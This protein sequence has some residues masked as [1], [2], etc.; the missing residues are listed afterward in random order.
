MDTRLLSSVLG[1]WV[2][3]ASLCR[4]QLAVANNIFQFTNQYFPKRAKWWPSVIR[5]IKMMM[6]LTPALQHRVYRPTWPVVFASDAEGANNTDHGGFGVV[7]TAVPLELA[8]QTTSSSAR[9]GLTIAKMDGTLKCLHNPEKELKGFVPVTQVP[10]ALID[11]NREWRDIAQGRWAHNDH[12]TLGEGRATLVLMERLAAMKET[13][14]HV[15]ASLCDNMPWCG[16]TNK[17]RSPAFRVNRLLR[18]RTALMV[19]KDFIVTHPWIDTDHMPADEI[20]R[21]KF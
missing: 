8:Q 20:S 4:S 13:Q 18:R 3:A 2:W 19:A 6:A 15:F 12:I 16:A 7:G 21:R 10:R 14:N 1:I 17:S 5:E 9:Q 11:G